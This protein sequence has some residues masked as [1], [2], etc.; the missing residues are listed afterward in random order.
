MYGDMSFVYDDGY[1]ED[2]QNLP[3]SHSLP[4]KKTFI[5]CS[6][7]VHFLVVSYPKPICVLLLL[8]NW[9]SVKKM[10]LPY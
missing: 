9:V 8:V 7:A 10:I 5:Q 4:V 1:L 2:K 6:N 3:L